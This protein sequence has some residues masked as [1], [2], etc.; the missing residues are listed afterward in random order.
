MRKEEGEEVCVAIGRQALWKCLSD[1]VGEGVVEFRKVTG[2]KQGEGGGRPKV[3]FENGE[4]EEAD[5]VVGADG[6]RS[7]VREAL[8]GKAGDSGSD[9]DWAPT[10]E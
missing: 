5:L 1:V 7:V 10:Y 6:V 8:F 3:T 4:V 2:V 9:G